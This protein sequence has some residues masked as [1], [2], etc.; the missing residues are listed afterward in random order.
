M[1]SI[2]LIADSHGRYV[3]AEI[4]SISNKSV[5]STVLRSAPLWHIAESASLQHEEADVTV[6]MGGT[7]DETQAEFDMGIHHL[8]NL[9]RKRNIAVVG[10]PQRY[11]EHQ[12]AWIRRKNTFL[13]HFCATNGFLYIDIDNASR[14]LYTNFGL[15]FNKKGKKWLARKILHSLDSHSGV[16]DT[17][18]E[19]GR[20]Q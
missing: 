14:D 8:N 20:R 19:K 11:D 2:S 12:E 17:F 7:N 18:L 10:V 6:I 9:A 13:Q 1:K 5:A 3:D 16:K 15:H 4:T